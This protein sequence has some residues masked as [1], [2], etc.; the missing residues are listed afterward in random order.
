MVFGAGLYILG[1]SQSI[2]LLEVG[3]I[4][5]FLIGSLLLIHGGNT[6]KKLWFPLFF[7]LFLIPLPGV[8]VDTL[9]QPMKVAVSYATEE[10]LHVVGYPIARTGVTLQIGAYQLLVAD[11]CAGL[12]TL[13]TLEAMGLL[14]LNVVRHTSVFRNISL[15]CMIVPI[16]FT[17]NVL[18]VI[19]LTLVTYYYGDEAGQGFIHGFAG[20]VLF[21][22]ALILIIG[23]DSLIRIGSSRLKTH[24]TI[25]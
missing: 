13:F 4:L 24:K 21:M 9:T 10:I 7:M 25:I 3:S 14:Y 16:S 22:S 8:I 11:A 23:A 12:N 15:A 1:R 5:W 2:L 19:I 17:A 20:M 6:V 18:R